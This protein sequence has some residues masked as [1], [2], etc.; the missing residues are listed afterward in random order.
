MDKDGSRRTFSRT[1][2]A[3]TFSLDYG[4]DKS[5]GCVVMPLQVPLFDSTDRFIGV[6]DLLSSQSEFIGGRQM[7]V[8]AENSAMITSATGCLHDTLVDLDDKFLEHCLDGNV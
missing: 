4:N 7:E 6:H 5:K 1:L 3:M 2:L 8:D